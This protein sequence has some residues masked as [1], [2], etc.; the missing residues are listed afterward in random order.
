MLPHAYVEVCSTAARHFFSGWF[1]H[2]VASGLMASQTDDDK[3]NLY[4][5]MANLAR[6]FKVLT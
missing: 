6:R 1:S 4:L 5:N 2:S 3:N